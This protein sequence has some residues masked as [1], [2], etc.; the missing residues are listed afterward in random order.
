MEM[1]DI[2]LVLKIAELKHFTKASYE[3]N[4]SE[5]S[6]SKR[7]SKLEKD[8]G[9]KIF[10]RSTRNVIVTEAGQIVVKYGEMIL[11]HYSN[12]TKE[13]RN[14]TERDSIRIGMI[15]KIYNDYFASMFSEYLKHNPNIVLETKQANTTELMESLDNQKLDV[16]IGVLRQ[17]LE[18]RLDLL[19]HPLFSDELVLLIN[20]DHRFHSKEKISLS[21]ISTEKFVALDV[22]SSTDM[23]IKKVLNN[24]NA[25]LDI[26]HRFSN[27]D[28]IMD[29]VSKSQDLVTLLARKVYLTHED[30]SNLKSIDI[31]PPINRTIAII[32]RKNVVEEF[33]SVKR[34]IRE[35]DKWFRGTL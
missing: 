7:I 1:F 3:L 10:D 15:S 17:D 32:T 31:I 18:S 5:S 4:I 30:N 12:M 28:I 8:L 34:F 9:I 24:Q 16:V 29:F 2:S 13:L 22:S 25:T 35:I 14:Y 6:L 11:E 19:I 27:P 21:E 26:V 23:I 20:K 33:P